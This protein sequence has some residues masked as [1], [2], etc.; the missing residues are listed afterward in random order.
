MSARQSPPSQGHGQV[1]D[2]LSWS[3]HS[4]GLLPPFQ[5]GGQAEVQAG[6]PQRPGQ[7]QTVGVGD[8]SGA[9]SGHRDPSGQVSR[10]ALFFQVKGTF[11]I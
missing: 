7:Q 1:G 10:Q 2:D 4:A 8:D 5:G 6:D 3:V 9:L 11:R